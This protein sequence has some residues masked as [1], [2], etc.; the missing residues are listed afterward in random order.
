MHPYLS[1]VAY[2]LSPPVCTL[3]PWSSWPVGSTLLLETWIET[4][5]GDHIVGGSKVG[6]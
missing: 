2:F 3:Q 6:L 4:G 1:K 5:F